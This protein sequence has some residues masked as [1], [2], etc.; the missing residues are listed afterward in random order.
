MRQEAMLSP[1]SGVFH[2]ANYSKCKA[3]KV[4]GS[5]VGNCVKV[6]FVFNMLEVSDAFV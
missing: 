3:G 4:G 5:I 1:R 6:M 2:C